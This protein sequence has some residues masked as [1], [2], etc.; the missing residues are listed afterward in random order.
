[1]HLLIC[2]SRSFCE[3][4]EGQQFLANK[5]GTLNLLLTIVTSN[6][7]S[8]PVNVSVAEVMMQVSNEI[9]SHS[10]LSRED[11][12]QILIDNPYYTNSVTHDT[13]YECLSRYGTTDVN[14]VIK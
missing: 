11:V 9:K 4:Q 6:Q 1:M 3:L 5:P 7:F 13:K 8:P 12:V 14:N 2:F 10:F